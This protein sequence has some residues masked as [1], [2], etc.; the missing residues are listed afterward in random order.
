MG[1]EALSDGGVA[2][3]GGNASRTRFGHGQELRA[4]DVQG[5]CR[6]LRCGRCHSGTIA[7]DSGSPSAI[8]SKNPVRCAAIGNAGGAFT[9]RAR[10]TSTID[11][12]KQGGVAA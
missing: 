4:Q 8:L 2:W 11:R 7:A 12:M 5:L 10:S 6:C 9:E 1:D 3:N